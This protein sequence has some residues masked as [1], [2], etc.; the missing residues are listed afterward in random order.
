MA[1]APERTGL[2]LHRVFTTDGVHPYDQIEWERRD[3]RLV[4]WRTGATVFE[5]LGVEVPAAW[6][7]NATNIL[8]QKYFRGRPDSPERESSLKEVVDRIVGTIADWG[9]RDG[10]FVDPAEAAIFRDELTF[11]MITQRVAF[12]SPVWFNIGVPGVPQQS[13]ACFIL[14]VDDTMDAILNWYVEEGKIF[15]RGSGAGVNLSRLRASVESLSGG[16]TAS[17]PVSFMRGADASAGTIKSGGTTR[18]AAKMVIL[19]ADHP[20]IE[21]FVW[22]KA[23]EE[24][25]AR[26]LRDAG[27]DVDLDGKDS[28]SLQYQNANNSVRLS[29][30]F[31]QAVVDDQPWPLTARH[32]GAVVKTLPARALFRQIAEA[33]W[34]CADPGLQFDTTINRWHTVPNSGRITAS[35]PCSEYLSLDNSACN[36]ASINLLPYLHDEGV[37]TEGF[38][39]EAFVQTVDVTFTAQEIL[40]GNSDYPTDKIGDTTRA[41]RQIGLGFANLGAL[42]MAL[43]L[44]YDSDGGR[45]VA[46]SITAL[47]TGRAYRMSALLAS[48]MGPFA[49][50]HDNREPMLRVLDMHRDALSGID[51]TLVSNELLGAARTAWDD[52][53]EL[54]AQLGVRNSQAVVIAPTGTISF[55]LDCDTTG[56]EPDLALVKNKKLV[57]GGTMAIVNRTVP[58]ALRR[59]GY[60]EQQ[61]AA[62]VAYVD[63]HKSVLGAPDL[64]AEHVAVFAC[65]MGDNAI[66]YKGHIHMLAAVQPWVSGSISKTC[67]LPEDVTVDEV[68]ALHLEAWQL[69]LKCV[70]IY[71][72]NCKVGQPMSAGKKG[73]QA[74]GA[75]A[76]VLETETLAPSSVVMPAAVASGA[77]TIEYRFV[78]EPVRQRLPRSRRS[79]TF[80]FRVADCKGFVTVGEYDD[81]RPGEIFVRVSKQGSTLAGIMDAFAISL[82]HGLQYG[83]PIKAFVE[84]FVGMRFEPAG[85]TDDPEI[86]IATSLID[87][88]FRRLG[89]EYLTV[90]ERAELNI[91]T[92]DERRQPTLPGVEEA[93]TETRQG[94]DLVPDPPSRSHTTA[95]AAARTATPVVT[96]PAVDRR[97][98]DAPLCMSCGVQM[99]RAGSCYVCHDCG[100]TSGCS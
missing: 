6:S 39:V 9:W 79:R 69:G 1:L 92:T 19:D 41:Y 2:G 89:V 63:E 82:S 93:V 45:A 75:P 84:A 13:S 11:A 24:R 95:S 72:D 16:G 34:D 23:K 8:A 17:G 33:A 4:D 61:V 46:S 99:Q 28:H 40:V 90:S 29:D 81:G 80:E 31:M 53:C 7:I 5:Q 59:L 10:Y 18:R 22:C 27:F 67:N 30:D 97:A 56:I 87:Y 62:I 88:L 50:F 51:T 26:A 54:G 77:P 48:R 12:N 3:A 78:H 86:R 20:D 52:A 21:D 44:P 15:Q 83:V 65:S 58:R 37:G 100:S 94:S 35:N 60:D 55:V 49:G 91:F 70:A 42:L 74:N 64:A 98:S 32:D 85:M 71:R 96:A 57:G 43:G 68:E 66:H 36:L 73:D 38:D 76:L 14:A 25:K 47:M